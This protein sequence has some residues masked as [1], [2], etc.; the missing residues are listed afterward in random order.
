MKNL[1]SILWLMSLSLLFANATFARTGLILPIPPQLVTPDPETRRRAAE[2]NTRN[3]Q[4]KRLEPGKPKG[5]A[6]PNPPLT[7]IR[8]ESLL[9]K[10]EKAL[11]MPNADDRKAHAAFL[12][13]EGTGLFKIIPNGKATIISV[14]T[15]KAQTARLPL[16]GGG[17]YYSFSKRC[18]DMD[19]W[20]DIFLQEGLLKVGIT[21]ESLS[22]MT[23]LSDIALNDVT[24][25][26][27]GIDYLKTFIPPIEYSKALTQYQK[28]AT[29]FTANH[30]LHKSTLPA[31]VNATYVLRS[32]KYRRADI[33][34]AFRILRQD[35]D[36]SLHILWKLLH[37]YPTPKL[38]DGAKSNN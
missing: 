30:L 17:A 37:K 20:A 34:L 28:S 4:Y 14:S 13:Q 23:I 5:Q 32:I 2:M 11:L 6:P 27:P 35:E 3:E 38:K 25:E 31:S 16:L 29:G 24:L 10:K 1:L 21:G 8:Q 15:G 19:E 7:L 26:T 36:G 33:L 22:L 12:E 18:H 9:L